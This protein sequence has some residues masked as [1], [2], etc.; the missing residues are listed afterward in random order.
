MFTLHA[1][2]ILKKDTIHR[3]SGTKNL[4]RLNRRQRNGVHN[5]FHQRAA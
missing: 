3:L 4:L 5:I 2:M 1:C